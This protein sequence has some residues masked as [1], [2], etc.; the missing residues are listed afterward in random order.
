MT[1]VAAPRSTR[2]TTSGSSTPS[3]VVE[4]ALAGGGEERVDELAL[5]GEV[6]VGLRRRAAH[7]AAGAAGELACGGR[8]TVHDRRD[9]LERHREQVVQDERE[10]LRRRQRLEH[11]Q[12]REA[13]AVGQQRLVLRAG[14]TIGSGRRAS[15]GSSRR[16]RRERSM[17][18][19]TRATTVVSHAR[20]FSTSDVSERLQPQPRLLHG[21]VGLVS[22]PS[23]R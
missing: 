5:A 1:C 7:A 16:A 8:G 23:I 9:R 20:R 21:V 10:P 3:S 13:D 4:V 11:D 6:G 17:S 18:S 22:E 19:E 12:Q 15:S 2:S 14:G